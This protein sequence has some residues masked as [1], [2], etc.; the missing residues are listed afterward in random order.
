MEIT[1]IGRHVYHIEP[2]GAMRVPGIVFADE[3]L[4]MQADR[5]QALQQVCNVATLPGI[6]KAS[7]AMPDIHW[8]YG[9]PIGGVA[10]MSAADDGVVSPGGV[11][12]DINCG[13]RLLRTDLQIDEVRPLVEKLLHEHMRR[14]PTGTNQRGALLVDVR[15]LRNVVERG[16]AWLTARGLAPDDDAD[17]VEDRGAMPGAAAAAV[18]SRA[19]ERGRT[20]LG[21]LGA[22]NHFLELQAVDEVFD[23]AVAAAFGLFPG[24]VTVMIHSGSRGFGHQTCTDYLQR[25]AAAVGRWGYDLPDRQLACAP[26]DSQEGRDYLAAMACAANFAFVNR[27]VIAQEVR[28]AF[29]QVMRLPWERLG[30]RVVYDVGHNIVKREVHDVDGEQRELWVHRKGATRAFGPGR[31]ELAEVYRDIGQPVIVPGDMGSESWIAVGTATGMQQSF[32]SACHG[33]GRSMSRG[34]A[35]KVMSGAD[36]RRE[37]EGKGIVIRAAS[38]AL[39]SEEAPYAYKDVDAVVRVVEAAGLARRVARLKPIGVLKG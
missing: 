21:S 22:G 24:Q 4:L 34:A 1:R 10:A 37:L 16:A 27:A 18:S 13:V 5:Q 35:K 30:M 3:Q 20:Q 2:E 38:T 36:V 33:A 11:G 31:P 14:I 23:P 7:I 26:I 32:G 8:G 25:M 15:E 28:R 9:F 39:L 6:V 29:E 19:L 17:H 12:F